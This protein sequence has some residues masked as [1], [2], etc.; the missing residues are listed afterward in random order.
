MN[1]DILSHRRITQATL[2]VTVATLVGLATTPLISAA[3]PGG[4]TGGVLPAYQGQSTLVQDPAWVA[5][6]D[7][8]RIARLPSGEVVTLA[9]PLTSLAPLATSGSLG[10][11]VTAKIVE[12]Q[13]N[14]YDDKHV[15]I[16]DLNYWN[17]CTAGGADVALYYWKPGNVTGWTAGNFSEPYGPHVSTTYWANSD[18]G[19]S[20]DTSDGYATQGRAYLMYLAE[21][22]KPPTYTNP[23]I[24][25]FS[26][27]PTTGGSIT[28]VRDALNWEASGHASGWSSFWYHWVSTSGL[29]AAT[30]QNDVAVDILSNSA[31]VVDLNT[32]VS[33]SLHLP[34]WGHNVPHTVTIVGYDNS[35]GTYT[36]LDTCGVS[37][38]ST[39]NGGTHTV[40]QSTM[41]Q[42]IMNLGYGFDW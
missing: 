40:S 17:F 32:Y 27:Y 20:S 37:C 35:A 19:T 23:G 2:A 13:G 34:N 38:G 1:R 25:S 28:D 39:S 9:Q 12:P 42:L 11:S 26:S 36:Y 3:D 6:K 10:T 15:A 30:L 8:D 29:T 16:S 7:A 5:L 33:S 4:T 18:T 14:N 22:V 24:I 31:V 41:Y 21:Q